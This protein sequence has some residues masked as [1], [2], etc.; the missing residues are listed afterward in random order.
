M[1]TR[2]LGQ[3]TK[4]EWEPVLADRA[5]HGREF[6]LSETGA[7]RGFWFFFFFFFGFG[8]F[9]LFRPHPRHMEIPRLEVK[10]EL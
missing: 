1:G 5:S 3:G 6:D 10:S 7:T 9:L 2:G 4:S 8:F